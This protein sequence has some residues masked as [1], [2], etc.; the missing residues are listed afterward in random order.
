[1]AYLYKNLFVF[2]QAFAGAVAGLLAQSAQPPVAPNTYASTIAIA[3]AW[4]QAVDT[5]WGTVANPDQ[6]EYAEIFAYSNDLFEVYDPQPNTGIT[7]IGSSTNPATYAASAA[8]LVAAGGVLAAGETYLA[9]IGVPIAPIPGGSTGNYVTI[10]A[11]LPGTPTSAAPASYA[12]AAIVTT[13]L[14]SGMFRVT[15]SVTMTDSSSELVTLKLFAAEQGVAGTPI[16]LTGGTAAAQLGGGVVPVTTEGQVATA[17][18]VPI[19]LVGATVAKTLSTKSLQ[20]VA[21]DAITISITGIYSFSV[22][23]ASK[24]PFV[25]DETC[26]LYL[27]VTAAAGAISAMNVD[28]SVEELAAV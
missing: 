23:V 3:G 2:N 16:T 6:F 21:T 17:T 22:G 24:I 1:M 9:A 28:F 27:G 10:D 14:A 11:G 13:P 15:A 26:C 8:A 25:L 12:I 20:A 5:A 19:A 7:G 18:T 4:A